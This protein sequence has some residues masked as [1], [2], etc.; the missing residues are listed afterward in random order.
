MYRSNS[1]PRPDTKKPQLPWRG[2]PLLQICQDRLRRVAEWG[3]GK[4][5]PREGRGQCRLI[6]GRRGT[7]HGKDS[8][9]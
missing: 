6:Y 9:I 4:L 5:D 8:W 7:T 2:V 1:P 3:A